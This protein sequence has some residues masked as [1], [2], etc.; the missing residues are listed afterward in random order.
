L[1]EQE[2]YRQAAQ[3]ILD[4]LTRLQSGN[5]TPA[6]IRGGLS[7]SHPIWG[8]YLRWRYPN[9]SVKFFLD[10]LLQ[11]QMLPSFSDFSGRIGEELFPSGTGI[12]KGS[13]GAKDTHA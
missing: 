13:T 11:E 9:W 5:N 7:G 8:R 3:R 6:S 12:I 4:F 1:T 2:G 10:A